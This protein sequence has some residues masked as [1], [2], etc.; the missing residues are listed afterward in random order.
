MLGSC[1]ASRQRDPG[2]LDRR[3][4]VPGPDKLPDAAKKISAGIR[5]LKKQGRVLQQ[6]IENDEH[7]GGAIR[8]LKSA[9]RGDELPVRPQVKN[10]IKPPET[11]GDLPAEAPAPA[12]ADGVDP[13]PPELAEAKPTLPPVAG[14]RD[15]DVPATTP[16]DLAGIIKPPHGDVRPRTDA[17]IEPEPE[18]SKQKHG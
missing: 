18:S 11:K 12:D 8:D 14:E 4:P 15:P 9:L 13:K 7:I 1:L 10:V 2:D 6:T 16:D 3:A 17:A 5:D